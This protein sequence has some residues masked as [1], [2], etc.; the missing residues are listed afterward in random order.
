MFRVLAGGSAG[1]DVSLTRRA[2]HGL[3]LSRRN[4]RRAEERR[5][6]KS[7]DRKFGSHQKGLLSYG[8]GSPKL[9]NGVKPR[10]GDRVPAR[11][12]VQ[13]SIFCVATGRPTVANCAVFCALKA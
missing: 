5:N 10:A 12:I 3:A 1:I 7:R 13:I 6:G 4:E 8:E 9:R 2:G 11:D